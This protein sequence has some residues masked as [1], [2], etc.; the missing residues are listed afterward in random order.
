MPDHLER[1]DTGVEHRPAGPLFNAWLVGAAALVVLWAVA[2]ADD[3]M[4]PSPDPPNRSPVVTTAIPAQTI[5]VGE[6][7]AIDLSAHFTDPDGDELSFAVETQDPA[8]ATATVSGSTLTLAAVSQGTSEITVTARDPGELSATQNFVVAVPNR[9]PVVADSIAALELV[10]SDSVFIDLSDHFTD[11]DGDTLGFSVE[12]SDETVVSPSVSAD[13]LAVVAMG[14]GAATLAVTATDPRGASVSMTVG[15]T[16]ANRSPV[17]SDSIPRLEIVAGD[18]VAI[19]L[20]DHFSDPDGDTL[21]FSVEVSDEAVASAS[22]SADTL[23]VFAIRPGVASMTV[24]AQDPGGLTASQSVDV[25]VP[26]RA[27]I[28]T[29]SIAALEIFTSDSA[30]IDLLA[31]FSDP[32]GDTLSF[33][34]ETSN[35]AVA[36]VSLS[37][38]AATIMAAGRGTAEVTVT[39]TDPGALAASQTLVVIVPNRQPVVTEPIPR[40]AVL[41]GQSIAIELLGHFGDP[42]GDALQF[43]ALTSDG[44]VASASTADAEVTIVSVG[45]GAAEVTVVAQDPGDL[46]TAQSFLVNVPANADRD[47][48]IALYEATDGP[49]WE[50]QTNWLSNAPLG[51]W[52][53]V[54]VNAEGRVTG[55]NLVSNGLAGHLPPELGWLT[56]LTSLDLRINSLQGHLPPELA[57]LRALRRLALARNNL[58]GAIPQEFDRLA[59]LTELELDDNAL[60][61]PIP[62]G[63]AALTELTVLRLGRNR[64]AGPIPVS[65]GNLSKLEILVLG[66]GNLAGS[67]PPELGQLHRLRVLNLG[68][69]NLTGSIPPELGRLSNLTHLSLGS[70]KLSGVIP[71]GLSRLRNLSELSLS[72]NDLTGSILPELGQLRSLQRLELRFNGLTGPIPPELG[73][74]AALRVLHLDH[75]LLTGSIPTEFGGLRSLRIL[76][77]HENLLTG[78]LPATVG[79]LQTLVQLLTY[80]NDGLCIPGVAAFA[81]WA[82][83][84]PEDD[85]CNAADKAALTTLFESTGGSDWTDSSGWLGGP[86]LELWQGVVTD[87]AGRV[88]ELDLRNN[89]LAGRL[90]SDLGDRLDRLSV[91]R[92]GENA[93][94]GPLPSS[95]ARIELQE[96]DYAGTG[97]CVPSDESLKTWLDGIPVRRGPLDECPL[98]SDREILVAL[99][100]ATNGENWVNQDNWLTNTPLHSWFGVSTDLYGRVTRIQLSENGLTGRLPPELGDLSRLTMLNLAKNNLSGSIPV[101]L[102]KLAELTYLVLNDNRL[103]GPIPPALGTLSGLLSLILNANE[104]SGG[105]PPALGELSRLRTLWM[106]SNHLSGSIPAELGKLRRLNSLTLSSNNL[107]GRIPAALGKLAALRTLWLQDN[108]LVGSILPEFRNLR[109]LQDLWVGENR[110]TGPIPAALGRLAELRSL[111][112]EYNELSGSIPPELG[113]LANLTYL[114]LRF[115]DLAGPI[116]PELG[117]LSNLRSLWLSENGLT[118][119]MPPELGT[120]ADAYLILLDGNDL[121]GPLPS[122]VGN[123][124]SLETLDLSLNAGLGGRL[125]RTLTRLER[126]DDLRLRGTDFC[127]ADDPDLRD[128]LDGVGVRRMPLC[129]ATAKAYLTQAVQSRRAPVPLVAGEE[130][131]LRVF[132]TAR[133]VSREPLPPVRATFFVGG[134]EVYGVEIASGPG[135]IPTWVDE[136]SLENSANAL[137]PGFVVQPGLE[138]MIEVQPDGG[139]DTALGVD[140][141]IPTT[142]RIALDV[143]EMPPMD[144]TLIPFLWTE[145]PDSTIVGTIRD[146]A[147]DPENHLLLRDTR[148]LLPV[149]ELSVTAHEPVWSSD[150]N[151]WTLLEQ[152]EAIRAM[153]GD[154]GHYMGMLAG[155]D[156][157]P[158]GIGYWPGRV[159]FSIPDPRVIAHELGHNMNLGHAPCSASSSLDSGFP[160]MDGSIGAWGYDFREGRGLVDPFTSDLMSYCNPYWISEY[161]F[162]TALRYRLQSEGSG[163]AASASPSQSLLLWGGVDTDG[164]PY[165]RPTFVV[166]APPRLPRPGTDYRLEGRDAAGA[167]LFSLTFDIP[168]VADGEGVGAFAFVVP[169]QPGWENALATVNLSGPTGTTATQ[170]ALSDDPMAILL[171]RSGRVRGFLRDPSV[172]PRIQATAADGVSFQ[173]GFEVLFSRGIPDA[174]E[175]RR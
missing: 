125:P 60:T 143:S 116:P 23:A 44:A 106:S 131:L 100:E 72:R 103:T 157:R 90:P 145:D 154:P 26:N 171:D 152:T 163:A 41:P 156:I 165:L 112:L 107:N 43:T 17:L 13:T 67:I 85:L 62:P 34:A 136:S 86:L 68:G 151:P 35:P 155:E 108:R 141:R 39:A 139:L 55:L 32:D 10:P 93:L 80:G 135:P 25:T 64:L 45:P 127:V 92:I 137:I 15:V 170:S 111:S 175:W 53:G 105:I 9:P 129:A 66:P 5:P 1:R 76:W 6:T 124:A 84:R 37:G 30:T 128:W 58:T 160:Q 153:E 89:G 121:T 7:A 120:L 144:L 42:D 95:L 132:P 119:P 63:L 11:P 50:E 31:H 150:D 118:G 18:S 117:A 70:N 8:V 138:M 133:Q 159:S 169:T 51:S 172:D 126:L 52:E 78:P 140:R 21:G 33:A 79:D 73:R 88:L 113:Q 20:S 16:V 24:T 2:C 174:A 102:G 28:L 101:E 98:L 83:E 97:L 110:L 14:A 134:R 12:A 91:L 158:L 168:A 96:F 29:D 99:H 173:R 81:V 162:S 61:G 54:S 69:N 59:V 74:M 122:T 149:N 27:P 4:Q 166:E 161:G 114:N 123:L 167:E 147:A 146:M 142:G 49:N 48:L 47:A 87:S 77:L 82:E 36:T 38:H 40:Q 22:V 109:T 71:S 75:N 56:E 148:T 57:R 104:L 65:L 94:S 19:A 130:A 115:N 164:N 46:S 3:P